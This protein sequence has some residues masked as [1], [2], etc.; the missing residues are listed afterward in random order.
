MKQ[1]FILASPAFLL[2]LIALAV[3]IAGALPA[4]ADEPDAN[5]KGLWL[6][7][8]GFPK[9]AEVLDFEDDPDW[10]TFYARSVDGV[11]T[12]EIRRQEKEG[13]ELQDPED[14]E[15]IISMRAFNEEDEED[16]K[17]NMATIKI[18][19][20]PS[21]F[22]QIYKLPCAMAEYQTGPKGDKVHNASLFIF[23]DVYCFLVE[24]EITAGLA[25]DYEERLMGW[26]M[27]LEFVER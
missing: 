27:G 1:K 19:E 24:A 26:F 18:K 9:G 12:F 13:S 23:T 11:L 25:K 15:N 6:R 16:G 4:A 5:V 10:A 17:A 14:V 7:C 20:N 22:S 3:L 21:E 2:I 8:P